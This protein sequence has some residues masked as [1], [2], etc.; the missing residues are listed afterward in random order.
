MG[1]SKWRNGGRG[2]AST[3]NLAASLPLASLHMAAGASRQRASDWNLASP[4]SPPRRKSW[5][6]GKGASVRQWCATRRR[7]RRARATPTGAARVRRVLRGEPETEYKRWNASRERRRGVGS[8]AL[9][10][11]LVLVGCT[12]NV[13]TVYYWL[14]VWAS[15]RK[16]NGKVRASPRASLNH[17]YKS[18]WRCS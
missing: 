14:E 11:R 3:W 18:S 1:E 15:K 10:S 17:K 6:A 9:R 5:S 8:W 13:F 16:A 2:K 4:F 7:Q 12:T